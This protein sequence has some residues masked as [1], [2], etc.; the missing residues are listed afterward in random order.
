MT[1]K[2]SVVKLIGMK[3][4]LCVYVRSLSLYSC[5]CV[6]FFTSDPWILLVPKTSEFT[7]IFE[8]QSLPPTVF[9]P[10]PEP[11][12]SFIKSKNMHV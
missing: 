12:M 2:V 4:F 9:W 10:E 11:I 8:D 3:T 1:F 6:F 7:F 5:V